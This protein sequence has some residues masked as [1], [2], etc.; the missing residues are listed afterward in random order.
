M[1]HF[2]KKKDGVFIS[3]HDEITE[4][5]KIAQ[6]LERFFKQWGHYCELVRHTKTTTVTERKIKDNLRACRWF[7]QLFTTDPS[8]SDWMNRERRW[9]EGMYDEKLDLKDVVKFLYTADSRRK[10]KE[11]QKIKAQADEGKIDFI[12]IDSEDKAKN[13]LPAILFDGYLG[14][15]QIGD[16]VL[17]ECCRK[18]IDPNEIQL[19]AL[20][21]F[22][23]NFRHANTRGL[24]S[25]LPDKWKTLE[26]LKSQFQQAKEGDEIRM[27]GF[28]LNRYV[29]SEDEDREAATGAYFKSAIERGGTARLLLLDQNFH[30]AKERV[31]IESPGEYFKNT[32]FYNDSVEVNN[33]YKQGQ[34]TQK[35]K[36]KYYKTPYVGMVLFRDRIFVELYHLGHDGEKDE[37]A[38]KRTICGRVPVLV[39]KKDSPFYKL[40]DSHFERIWE[41]L[42]EDQMSPEG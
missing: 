16:V 34:Y 12:Q 18:P 31:K 39:I 32:V 3:F 8:P 28:T 30:A 27:I 29:F 40:F 25:V 1:K 9:F 26:P 11:F 36:I 21:D 6:E 22:I 33:F 42:A 24:V 10:G 19:K 13:V 38:K 2:D 15:D 17:P 4:S 14:K 37:K 35:V 5:I 23:G 41:K 20:E 7:L